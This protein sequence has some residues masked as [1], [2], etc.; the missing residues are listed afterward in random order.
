MWRQRESEKEGKQI[1]KIKEVL[2]ACV[3]KKAGKRKTI[4]SWDREYQN[5]CEFF[6]FTYRMSRCLK[7][8][9][10]HGRF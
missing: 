10:A 7:Y 1:R 8:L 4:L 2:G 9:L 5:L 6:F 3:C